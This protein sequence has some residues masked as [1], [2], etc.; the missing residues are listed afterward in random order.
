MT[1]QPYHEGRIQPHTGDQLIASKNK[2][3]EMAL[4]D[5]ERMMLEESRNKVESYIYRIKNKLED[6][7]EVI[8]VVTTEEQREA[9][10]K[11]AVDAEDW[12]YDEGYSADLAT[13]EDKYA[14]L[15]VP[16]EFVMLRVSEMTARPAAMEALKK[17]LVDVEQLM[18]KWAEDRPQVTE[19]ERVSVLEKVEEVRKWIV[20]M[21]EAQSKK[22][23]HEDP[24]FFSEDVPKQTSSIEALVLKLS[25]RP[26]PKPPKPE[27]NETESATNDTATESGG[28]GAAAGDSTT[29][30]EG[31]A[32][33]GTETATEGEDT[34]T[35]TG[36]EAEADAAASSSEEKLEDE[37]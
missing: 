37:L 15:S 11:L 36:Q 35:A 7:A 30:E 9:V 10:R 23:P 5:K 18:V 22:Q 31:E 19:E 26:K 16:F 4:R 34:A 1:V 27:K 12:L 2:L 6:D 33:A 25:K 8:G 28:E 29:A 3:L 24:A 13:M 17:K 20:D 32:A 21:E 14:E